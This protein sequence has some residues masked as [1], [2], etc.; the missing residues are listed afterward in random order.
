MLWGAIQAHAAYF[1]C[2]F[3]RERK[4][5]SRNVTLLVN[6]SGVLMAAVLFKAQRERYLTQLTLCVSAVLA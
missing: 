6:Y 3:N 2:S 5:M 1:A 4:Q